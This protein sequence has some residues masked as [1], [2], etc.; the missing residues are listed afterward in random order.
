MIATWNVLRESLDRLLEELHTT[1][2]P[3]PS[4]EMCELLIVGEDHRFWTHC[5]VD[6]RALL[7]ALFQTVVRASPQ[8][9]S[10]IAMQLVRTLTGRYERKLSR[11]LVEIAL[12]IRLTRYLGRSRIP[13][14]YLWVAYYGWR[15]NNLRQACV[16]LGV[17]PCSTDRIKLARLVAR[18]KYPQPRHMS[19][20]RLESIHRRARYLGRLHDRNVRDKRRHSWNLFEYQARWER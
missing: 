17:D 2:H 3:L 6:A 5:G 9:G 18:L 16:R 4:R 8:G 15:M 20:L 1:N 11:K 7:R 14:L 12:A 10:T 13:T 19:T